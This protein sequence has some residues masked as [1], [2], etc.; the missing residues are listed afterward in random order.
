[1][2]ALVVDIKG[3]RLE[4]RFI[5]DKGMIADSFAIVKGDTTVMP[6]QCTP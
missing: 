3:S 2:G 1:M 4:G 5:T 6:L